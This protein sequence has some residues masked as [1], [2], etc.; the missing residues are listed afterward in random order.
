MKQFP[1][2]ALALAAIPFA[3]PSACRPPRWTVGQ[4]VQTTSGPVEGH[5]ASVASGVSEYLGIPYAQP[6]V[7]SLRFQP[8]VR[9]NGT[10]KID[11]KHF[12][13]FD[14]LPLF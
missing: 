12:V 8:P 1:S 9:Y 7:G 2:V 13:C 4:T 5:A 14:R 11:G 10:T 3:A 6:P